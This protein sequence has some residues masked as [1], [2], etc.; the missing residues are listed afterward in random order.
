MNLSIKVDG[1]Q[2]ELISKN[3]EVASYKREADNLR[4]ENQVDYQFAYLK[5]PRSSG[6]N[7]KNWITW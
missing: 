3:V 1:T 2:K 5:P 4:K 6:K 7:W